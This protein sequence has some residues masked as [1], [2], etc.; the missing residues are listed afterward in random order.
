[1]IEIKSKIKDF[2]KMKLKDDSVIT[3]NKNSPFK[4]INTDYATFR[5][6]E[7][8]NTIEEVER[9][10]I[11]DDI[12]PTD[13]IL[14]I[15]A[16]IGA[17]SLKVCK[18]ANLVF[19]VEP[20]M[21]EKLK[22]NIKLNEVDN[23]VV[24]NCAL[25]NGE[26]TLEWGGITNKIQCLSLSEIIDQCGGHVDFLKID[27]EGNFYKKTGEWCIKPDELNGIR[28]IE[29]EIH[30]PQKSLSKFEEIL[31][32]AGFEYTS[33]SRPTLHLHTIHAYSLVIQ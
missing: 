31:K 22:E 21:T 30:C 26:Q 28:R 5:F 27:C 18:K 32:K 17:F 20:I 13:I 3:L 11:I 15:G 6:D 10:Y 2:L 8:I 19:A 25:G 29:A 1:M 33:S 14:D 12:R 24:L 7:N 9:D 16:C 23:I 4:Y